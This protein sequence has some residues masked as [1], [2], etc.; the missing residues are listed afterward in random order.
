MTGKIGRLLVGSAA[1]TA[2]ALSVPT[3]ALAATGHHSHS[4]R[5]HAA[6]AGNASSSNSSTSAG[7]ETALTGTTLASASSAALASVPGTVESAT[8]ETDGTGAYEVI[9][10][11]S[12][13]TRVKV[14]EDA[15]FSVLSSGATS[16]H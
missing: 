9:V 8:T 5:T 16:C 6:K 2:I 10:T 1:A 15:S 3:G 7:A 4:H 14:V 13:G 11:K 12:D